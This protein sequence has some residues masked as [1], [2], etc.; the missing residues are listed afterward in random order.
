METMSVQLETTLRQ[1][2][3]RPGVQVILATTNREGVPHVSVVEDVDVDD[4][5]RIRCLERSEHS[6]TNR[7]LVAS[8]WFSRPVA[9]LVREN[10]DNSWLIRAVPHKALVAGPLFE[11]RYRALRAREGDV[12]LST[13]WLL[14]PVE[15]HDDSPRGRAERDSRGRLELVHLDRIARTEDATAAA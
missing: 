1:R 2:I 8:L 6:E 11:E 14:D 7:N 15:V 13:V 9:L 10:A 3:A 5:G 4:D 12:E